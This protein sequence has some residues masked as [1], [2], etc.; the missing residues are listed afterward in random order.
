MK[1]RNFWVHKIEQAWKKRSIIWLTGVRRVGKTSLCQSLENIEYFD[2]ELPRIRR[3]FEDPESFLKKMNGKRCIFDEIH[4]LENP[5]EIL[6]IAS[7][8]YP[9]TTIIATGS[10]TLGASAKFKD[11]LTG[12]KVRIWLTPLLD[13]ERELFGSQDLD[14]RML[15]GGLPPFFLADE[16]PE[17]E[18]QEWLDSYWA[19]DVQEL[20]RLEKRYS[21]LK[22]A[23][24]LMA[25]SGSSFE[26]S[27]FAA[28]CEVSRTTIAN[29]LHVLEET[30]IAHVIRP[31]TSYK[32]TEIV[33][34]PKIYGFD[35]GFVCFCK[36]WVDLRREDYGLL[37]EHLVLNQIQGSLQ[38]KE[39]RYWRT[40]QDQEIDF[41]IAK[42][43]GKNPIAIECKWTEKNANISNFKSFRHAYPTGKNYVV[44]SDVDIPF[45]RR[46]GEHVVEF[47]SLKDLITAL[48]S[49]AKGGSE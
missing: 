12:R 4:R 40:K 35:S 21:F 44:A 10:S 15:Y 48:S 34:A 5:A 18:Y 7:D 37:W 6:K 49:P 46:I 20:Y 28:P 45:E 30:H 41:V 39:I 19:K 9:K 26:A 14:H 17:S 38:T 23:E 3:L 25:Q 27:K 42:N 47:V 24:L 11:T 33:S 13:E 16:L 31:F 1:N 43:R 32:P 29:Y 36:G 2:C 22:F 8:H